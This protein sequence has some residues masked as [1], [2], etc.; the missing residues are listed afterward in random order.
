MQK[1]VIRFLMKRILF[2]L[3]L[4]LL[5]SG[6][7]DKN[8]F[9]VNGVIKDSKEK[10]IYISR[11]DVDTPILIDSAKIGRKGQFHF[12]VKTAIPEFYQLG[13]SSANFITLLAEPGEK[14]LLQFSN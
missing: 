2:L 6:C 7:K 11:L 14:I 13:F 9:A 12:R 8:K 3:A 1:L 5:F 10:Y 4:V